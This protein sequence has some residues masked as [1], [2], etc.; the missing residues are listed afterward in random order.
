MDLSPDN[1]NRCDSKLCQY[2]TAC[3]LITLFLI[4]LFITG[5]AQ[6]NMSP[7][8]MVVD[9]R[10]DDAHHKDVQVFNLDKNNLFM[11]VSVEKVLSPGSS[12]DV[13][14]NINGYRIMKFQIS[15]NSTEN[16]RQYS[17]EY[18]SPKYFLHL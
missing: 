1:R 2:A 4:L 14:F 17:S 7:D 6:A 15:K 11:N 12:R 8:R 3:N 10:P 5:M 9:F 13:S 18:E 16:G